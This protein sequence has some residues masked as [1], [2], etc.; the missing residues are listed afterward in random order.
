MWFGDAATTTVG[1]SG[2]AT[3]TSPPPA[4]TVH[5]LW[6]SFSSVVRAALFTAVDG[7]G[8]IWVTN[9]NTGGITEFS[10]QWHDPFARAYRNRNCT[11]VGYVHSGLATRGTSSE[12]T[13][14]AISGSRTIPRDRLHRRHELDLRA[15]RR[16]C[17]HCHPNRSC[18]QEQHHRRQALTAFSASAETAGELIRVRR[19][20]SCPDARTSSWQRLTVSA[21]HPARSAC[22]HK[23]SAR[24]ALHDT[25]K[26]APRIG[27]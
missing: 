6:F 24:F 15:C 7:A 17:S 4:R 14:P 13:L 23:S 1:N 10:K 25:S 21:T 3:S 18:P 12:S 5:E 8:N 16:G 27:R 19:P 22:Y 2:L 11:P 20:F 26:P 9:R